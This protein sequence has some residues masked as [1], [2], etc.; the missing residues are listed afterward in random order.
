MEQPWPSQIGLR[1]TFLK[2]RHFEGQNFD[3]FLR[4]NRFYSKKAF[5]R[6][7]RRATLNSFKGRGLAMA[8]IEAQ[9]YLR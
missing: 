1:A 9:R 4:S 3:F 7:C 8:G 2:N 5:F 6:D